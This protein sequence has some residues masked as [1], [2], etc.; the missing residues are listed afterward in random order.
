MP[1]PDGSAFAVRRFVQREWPFVWHLHPEHELT[2]ILRGQGRRHVGDSIEDFGPGDLVLLGS[3]L[4]H[5][6]QAGRRDD[7]WLE[8]VVIQFRDDAAGAGFFDLPEMEAIRGLLDRAQRGLKFSASGDVAEQLR[9]LPDQPPARRLIGLLD[10]LDRLAQAP[11]DALSSKPAKA[12]LSSKDRGRID[13]VCAF[14]EDRQTEALSLDEVAEVAH[15]SR[16]AFCRFFQRVMGRTFTEYLHELRISHACRLLAE[17]DLPVA[18]VAFRVGFGN[19]AYFNRVFK[20]A[21]GTTPSALRQRLSESP[22]LS[23]SA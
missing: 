4:P 13:E 1:T 10:C 16:T 18:E 15:L 8:S 11:N 22:Y 3:N 14:I 23:A 17:T 20:R 12:K 7:C 19:L 2:L 6:W 9:G 5:T 21:R